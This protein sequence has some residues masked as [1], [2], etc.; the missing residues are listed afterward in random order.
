MHD[1]PEAP[2]LVDTALIPRRR[3]R[4]Q[5]IGFAGRGDFLFRAVAEIV[6]ERLGDLTRRFERAAVIGSGGGVMAQALQPLTGAL[7]QFELSPARAAASDATPA[8]TLDP[9]PLA[10]G[11]VDLLVSALE[12]HWAN[13][14]VGQMIQMRR[15]LTPDG[16]L[17]AAL[18][19][20]ETLTELRACLAEAEIAVAGGLSPRIAPMGEIRELGGLLQR[21]GLA[22]PV[23]DSERI[24]ATYPD[25]RALML[26]IRAMG[27]TNMLAA[28]RRVPLGRSV[29]EEAGRLYRANFPAEDGR[30]AATFEIVFLTGWAPGPN[31]PLPLRPGSARM[32]LADALGTVETSTGEAAAPKTVPDR[33]DAVPK[34]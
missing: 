9:L 30:I 33:R 17:I 28:R 1:Q 27:E 20:G 23:A 21:A 7:T 4:A 3:D 24:R 6:A 18:F 19:G 25:M 29:L 5:R 32:R 2:R 34:D 10:P 15:A 16:L 12:L 13:D 8:A 14:P 11:S 26:D 22:M 31:Q